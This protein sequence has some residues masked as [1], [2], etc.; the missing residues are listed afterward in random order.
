M[1]TIPVEIVLYI[2]RL[3]S[4]D[5]SALSAC[6]RVCHTWRI[7]VLPMLYYAPNFSHLH[8][9]ESFAANISPEIGSLVKEIDTSMIQHRWSRVMD[10]TIIM[11]VNRCRTIERLDL[12]M[13]EKM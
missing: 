1:D 13:C 11:L 2:L 8:A 6:V 5:Q 10:N 12:Y 7:T 9:L 3:L 4:K